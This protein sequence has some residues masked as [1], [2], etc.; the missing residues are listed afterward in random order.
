MGFV[1]CGR[2]LREVHRACINPLCFAVS[3]REALSLPYAWQVVTG[4]S[5]KGKHSNR[6]RPAE[7]QFHRGSRGQR[8]ER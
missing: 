2:F 5:P 6:S 1:P 8:A 7:L 4:H 3:L